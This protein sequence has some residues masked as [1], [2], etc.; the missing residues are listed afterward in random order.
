MECLGG[1][2]NDQLR[3]NYNILHPDFALI[4]RLI[5]VAI[6]QKSQGVIIAAICN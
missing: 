3:A 6:E 1:I 5:I 2:I 4:F